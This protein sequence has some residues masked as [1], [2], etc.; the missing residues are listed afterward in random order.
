MAKYEKFE[1]FLKNNQKEKLTISYEFLK[2]ILG[3]SLPNSAYKYNAYF[4]NSLSHPLS[5]IWLELEYKQTKLVLGEYFILEKK[6]LN[7][8]D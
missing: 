5:K 4:S 1:I 2:N 3:F 8:N 7:I 6:E